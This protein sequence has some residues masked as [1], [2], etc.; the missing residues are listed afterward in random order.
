MR[1]AVVGGGPGGLYLAALARQLDPAHEVVVYERNAVDDTF[2]FGV[3][4]SDETLEGIEQADPV[5]FAR[6]SRRFA[7][8][9]D[10]DVRHR[11]R[12][13]TSGGHGFAAIN[14]AVLLELL[15]ARCAEGG[16][17]LRF[18]TTAPPVA[19]LRAQFDLVV[20]A[21]GARS[22]IRAEHADVFGPDLDVRHARYMW[23][24]TDKVFDAF[25][26]LVS[27]APHGA[28][29]VH[30]YPFSDERSTFIVEAAEATWRGLGFDAVDAETLPPG[31]SDEASTARLA[32]I[33]RQDLG[34]AALIANNSKWI[35]FTTVRNRR[36]H[37]GNLVLLG[38]AA[39]TAHFSIGS[40]TK[41]AMEDALALA[42][43]L[44]EH[45]DVP[46]ALAAYEAERRPVVE[47]TQR[48]AQASLEWFETVD[49]VT[50]QASEQFTF[51]LLTRSRRV[52]HDNLA[53]RDPEY[54]ASVRRWFSDGV[55]PLFHP[56]RL[57]GTTLRNR[58]VAAPVATHSARDGVPGDAEMLWLS[59]AAQGGAGL[60]LTGMTAVGANG[61]ADA[62]SSGLYTD[63][64]V[65]AWRTITDRI[66][67]V[68]GALVGVQLTHA[69][70]R[71]LVPVAPTPVPYRAGD[72]APAAPDEDAI[73]AA[74][75]A[76]ARRAADAAFDVLELHAGHGHL[77]STY[78]SPL[79]NPGDLT[80]RLRFPLRVLDAVRAVWEGPLLVRISA[81]DWAPGGNTISDAVQIARALAAAGADAIDVSS[82]EVVAEAEPA[83][84]RSYQ[85]PFAERIRHDAGIATIAVGGISTADDA[86]SIVLAGRADLVAVGRAMLH[87]PAWTLH[88]AAAAGWEGPGAEWPEH[89]RA[90]SAPP[91][92]G[93]R[94]PP[95]LSL[96]I[97]QSAPVHRRWRPTLVTSG[98][99]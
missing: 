19:S 61:R 21:D 96:T 68:T 71:G 87:N 77:L 93:R 94:V 1:I 47:S 36:W 85:T 92:S 25:T 75:V 72:P 16:V 52:T 98:K 45:P 39:H 64:H 56:L 38:D 40:G 81:V 7:R 65:A 9:T 11:G 55:P 14:R 12:T 42:A 3:V 63:A 59:S 13:I 35:R 31:V 2:G 99:A 57:G 24:G 83:Y 6:V 84:G 54:A 28:L 88:A 82:G 23:L 48:A 20:A 51:S 91:P 10:I 17:D 27:E 58:V 37:D 97:P 29:V 79:T 80:H 73:A 32:E 4:F 60:V 70:R 95:R 78:L 62:G 46:A 67:T 22:A 30:A 33:F 53:V 49:H 15:A 5:L 43:N 34:G 26:F 74:F 44:N 50:G 8:W 89:L 86:T 69:G 66:H 90:G 76:A 41:L 18:R